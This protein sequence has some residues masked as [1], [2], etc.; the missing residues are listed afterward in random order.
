MILDWNDYTGEDAHL[1]DQWLDEVAVAM[2]GI[3][4]GWDA[5]WQAV[6]ADAKNF[7]GCRDVC[8]IVRKD[9]LPIAVVAFGCYQGTAVISEIV[10]A[11]DL[12]SKG[13]GSEIIRELLAYSDIFL[14]EYNDR[15]TAV[16]FP[17]NLPSKKAFAK[18]GFVPDQIRD[19]AEAWVYYP[20]K[21][22]GKAD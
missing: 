6:L 5:Y 9:G 4:Q 21:T 17:D 13:Y 1:V 2:T 7:P 22:F 12:C 19:D 10:V 18:A 3:D 11:P 8:K 20:T 15:F 16:I 14:G